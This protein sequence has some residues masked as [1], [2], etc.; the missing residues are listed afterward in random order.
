MLPVS[1]ARRLQDDI[2]GSVLETILDCGHFLT[3]E[4]PEL[5]TEHLSRFLDPEP[6][7]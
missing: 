4:Q 2:R 3:E 6:V 5:V 1:I 7:G